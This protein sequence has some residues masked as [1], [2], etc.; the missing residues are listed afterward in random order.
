MADGKPYNI[1]DPGPWAIPVLCATPQ[2]KPV[3]LLPFA[4]GGV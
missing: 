1:G 2:E 4:I 3:F